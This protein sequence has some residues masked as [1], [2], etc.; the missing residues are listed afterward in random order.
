MVRGKYIYNTDL[1]PM[2][3]MRLEL[4]RYCVHRVCLPVCL[5][6][7]PHG[8][9]RFQLDAFSRN[10]G[11]AVFSNIF[12]RGNSSSLKSYKKITSTLHEDQFT[13]MI[14]SR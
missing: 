12:F 3:S 11:I 7:R 8:T 14:T 9:T 13:F 4:T 1:T 2:L 6:V 10:I 5:P